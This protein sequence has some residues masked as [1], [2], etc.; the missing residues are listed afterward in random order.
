MKA[1]RQLEYGK[2]LQVC[3]IPIP[4]AQ[5]GSAVVRILAAG[6]ISYTKDIYNG[7]RKYPYPTPLTV[8]TSAI[9]RIHDFGPDNTSLK[10]DQLVVIDVTFRSRSDPRDVFLSAIHQGFSS[11]SPGLMSYWR[12]GSYAE[13]MA[14]PL[15]NVYPLSEAL[16]TPAEQGG[17]GYKVEDLLYITRV[18]VP[19]GG[20]ADIGLR[21]SE[22][23]LIAPATGGFGSA[24]V[25][26]ALSMG[27]RV[28]AM[29]R[30]QDV[31]ASIQSNLAPHFPAGRVVTVPIEGDVDSL[32]SSIQK[33]AGSAPI[34]CF[35]DISPPAATNA[36]FFKAAILSIRHSGRV[37]LM[38]G[39]TGDVGIPPFTSHALEPVASRKMD[40]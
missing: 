34:D 22:T 20:L 16:L 4:Q 23:V 19:Y 33:A 9:G 7:V 18:L 31:L 29:G 28:I 3:E 24:A 38:G 12:D 10:K 13:Y 36:P 40:V 15:E 30:N 6:I 11:G 27:A 35:F 32:V 14:C 8:G 2:P 25:H 26:L 21:P 1:L 37:S 17:L 5:V 39:Q